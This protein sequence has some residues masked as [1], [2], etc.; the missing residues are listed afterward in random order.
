MDNILNHESI[1][2]IKLY[3]NTFEIRCLNFIDE[4]QTPKSFFCKNV[5]EYVKILPKLINLNENLHY[6][7]Y[8]APNRRDFMLFDDLTY[9]NIIKMLNDDFKIY[10]IVE[11]SL[12]NYQVVLR[13]KNEFSKEY[14]EKISKYLKYQYNADRACGSDVKRLHRLAGFYNKKAKYLLSFGVDFIDNNADNIE[15]AIIDNNKLFKC[16][17]FDMFNSIKLSQII[18]VKKSIK[19]MLDSY[20]NTEDLNAKKTKQIKIKNINVKDVDFIVKYYK[21]NVECDNYVINIYNTQKFN[22]KFKSMSEIDLLVCHLCKA[23][24][25]TFKEIAKSIITYR[26]KK[27]ELKHLQVYRYIRNTYKKAY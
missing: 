2:Q 27:L 16:K 7:I 13:F 15:N 20:E 17:F 14:Y 22:K 9:E 12:N 8:I 1:N 26:P 21:N 3:D 23:K 10:Y 24:K 5:N 25:F 19:L 4:K 18:D 11:T 6:N